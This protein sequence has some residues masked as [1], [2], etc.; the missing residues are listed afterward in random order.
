V[1]ITLASLG[2]A[3]TALLLLDLLRGR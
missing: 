2:G 1:P 3:L